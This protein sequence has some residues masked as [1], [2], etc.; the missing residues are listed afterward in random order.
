VIPTAIFK[1][2]RGTEEKFMLQRAENEA[3]VLREVLYRAIYTY[4][5]KYSYKYFPLIYCKENK[6][7]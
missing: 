1:N 5:I 6:V 2:A 4:I 3:S 7:N